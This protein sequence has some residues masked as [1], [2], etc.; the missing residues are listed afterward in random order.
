MTGVGGGAG[1][2]SG[3]LPQTSPDV[4]LVGA[5]LPSPL[6][7]AP[8][9]RDQPQGDGLSSWAACLAHQPRLLP[10]LATSWAEKAPY[11][12]SPTSGGSPP[13]ARGCMKS[14]HLGVQ[15]LA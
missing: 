3:A 8:A 1:S 4:L 13:G 12:T 6:T 9:G 7:L 11:P 5:S 14:V 10:I 2:S 15:S